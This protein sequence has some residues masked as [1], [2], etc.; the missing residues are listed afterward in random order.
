MKRST[1]VLGLAGAGLLAGSAVHSAE[2]A[3]NGSNYPKDRVCVTS[4]LGGESPY[5]LSKYSQFQISASGV[6]RR[7]QFMNPDAVIK[8]GTKGNTFAK[9]APFNVQL[10][11]SK[12]TYTNPNGEKIDRSSVCSAAAYEEVASTYPTLKAARRI[13]KSSVVLGEGELRPGVYNP[14]F[15]RRCGAVAVSPTRVILVATS[16]TDPS[17]ACKDFVLGENHQTSFMISGDEEAGNFRVIRPDVPLHNWAKIAEGYIPQKDDTLVY[18]GF[19][20][21][22]DREYFRVQVVGY[23]PGSMLLKAGIDEIYPD[24]DIYWSIDEQPNSA[25]SGTGGIF[26]PSGELVALLRGTAQYQ[27]CCNSYQSNEYSLR[28]QKYNSQMRSW[29]ADF[30]YTYDPELDHDAQFMEALYVSSHDIP[31]QDQAA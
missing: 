8:S 3:V 21:L 7:S 16:V 6:V 14:N 19:G 27:D 5:T 1:Q 2:K 26:T 31:R 30:G 20:E 29:L 28:L 17:R 12:S 13:L 15:T 25:K 23:R 11:K 18:S 24:E 9:Y 4:L 10:K 22:G